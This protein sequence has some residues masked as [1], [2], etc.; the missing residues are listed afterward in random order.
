MSNY[1][2]AHAAAAVARA[3]AAAVVARAATRAAELAAVVLCV[4]EA[5]GG[6]LSPMVVRILIECLTPPEGCLNPEWDLRKFY[7]KMRLAYFSER[8]L[9]NLAIKT[10]R[11]LWLVRYLDFS[12]MDAL[13][14]CIKARNY[15]PTEKDNRCP[16]PPNPPPFGYEGDLAS[17][18]SL[19]AKDRRRAWRPAWIVLGQFNI[20]LLPVWGNPFC[21]LEKK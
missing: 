6:R 9:D 3:A 21:P 15:V 11:A 16:N 13:L 17:Y 10:H 1:G 8:R 2:D 18:L 7:E 19:S 4:S 14:L 12:K 5:S 20:G